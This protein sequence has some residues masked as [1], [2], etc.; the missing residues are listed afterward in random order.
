MTAS[1][2]DLRMARELLDKA[3]RE[4]DPVKRAGLEAL[5]ESYW[6]PDESKPALTIDFEMPS[7]D[8]GDAGA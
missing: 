6:H 8:D 5:A 4:P 7:K 2:K 3:A 1:D